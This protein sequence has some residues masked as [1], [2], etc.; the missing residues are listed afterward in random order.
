MG[1]R[2]CVCK[3]RFRSMNFEQHWKKLKLGTNKR[4]WLIHRR[5]P[6][7][8]NN[9]SSVF[10]FYWNIQLNQFTSWHFFFYHLFIR[11]AFSRSQSIFMR[12]REKKNHAI[13]YEY[14]F[15][16]NVQMLHEIIEKNDIILPFQTTFQTP[17]KCGH[18]FYGSITCSHNTQFSTDVYSFLRTKKKKNRR[19]YSIFKLIER[20][21]RMNTK[22]GN[23]IP[24]TE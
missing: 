5:I 9:S 20:V 1:R 19:N 17:F 21:I 6:F 13:N 3:I 14:P 12:N 23:S 8:L 7:Q 4:N 22:I 16:W 10:D 11:I 15:L 2:F 24:R 18:L